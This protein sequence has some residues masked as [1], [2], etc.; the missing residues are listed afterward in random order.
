MAVLDRFHCTVISIFPVVCRIRMKTGTVQYV[1]GGGGIH[2][3]SL[4]HTLEELQTMYYNIN[5]L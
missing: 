4:V 2:F 5:G 3:I 1:G